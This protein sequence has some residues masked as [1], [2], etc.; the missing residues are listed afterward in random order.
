MRDALASGAEDENEDW[1]TEHG[2]MRAGSSSRLTS[3]V[4]FSGWK[5]HLHYLGQRVVRQA[6]ANTVVWKPSTRD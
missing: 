3:G 6:F 1:R 5:K 4:V 2:V